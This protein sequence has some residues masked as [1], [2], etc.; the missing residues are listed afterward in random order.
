MTATR[1]PE[2]IAKAHP[3]RLTIFGATGSGRH[4]IS[5][6]SCNDRTEHYGQYAEKDQSAVR[7]PIV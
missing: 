5:G 2:H 6:R 1:R 4:R 3:T 7:Y